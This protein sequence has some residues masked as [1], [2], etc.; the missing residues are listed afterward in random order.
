[1]SMA[2]GYQTNILT[3]SYRGIF[4]M[5]LWYYRGK[6]GGCRQI[7]THKKCVGIKIV[8]PRQGQFVQMCRHLA[9]TS[10]TFSAKAR[11]LKR[12]PTVRGASA[13]AVC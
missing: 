12:D 11:R 7:L 3:K 6:F 8:S 4:R 9:D 13:C 5:H 2:N 1:M 10:A